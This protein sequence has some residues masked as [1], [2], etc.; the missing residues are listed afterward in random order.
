[1]SLSRTSRPAGSE[2]S[3][4]GHVGLLA[5]LGASLL[6]SS[7]RVT[8]EPQGYDPILDAPPTLL[9]PRLT[10]REEQRVTGLVVAADAGAYFGASS[11]YKASDLSTLYGGTRARFG[12]SLGRRLAIPV[13]LTFGVALGFSETYENRGFDN[14][15]DIFTKAEVT[16]FPLHHL[17]WGLGVSGGAVLA[18]YDV[19]SETVSQVAYGPQLALKVTRDL[20]AYGQLYLDFSWSPIYNATA[21]YLRDPT[22]E[23]LEE[24][25]EAFKFKVKGEWGHVFMLSLG[26]RLFGF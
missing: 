7:A 3:R 23:E 19:E 6:A 9:Q 22:P 17:G 12:L 21:F 20:S 24:N 13:E 25:P 8:A 18:T 1:L 11:S 5:F 4:W 10:V 2:R 14:A 15:L 16:Y 26:V